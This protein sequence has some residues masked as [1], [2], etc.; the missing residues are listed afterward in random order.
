MRWPTPIEYQDALSDPAACLIAPD[1]QRS[2]ILEQTPYGSPLPV[3]GQFAHVYRL[4]Q[5]DGRSYAL[6]LFLREASDR[7][8]R[9][10]AI[11]AYIQSLPPQP[12]FVRFAYSPNGIRIGEQN[13]P[14]V[15][16]DWAEGEPLHVYIERHLNDPQRMKRLATD[17]IALIESLETLRIA[18]GD[19]QQDNLLVDAE[20]GA[21]HLIDYDGMFV[22]ALA[23][24]PS[25]E[26]GHP[27]YQHPQRDRS[28]FGPALDRFSALV[29]LVTLQTLCVAP[30]LWYRFHNGDN[31]LFRHE[32]FI[33][34]KE[35]NTF[36]TVRA[37]LRRSPSAS[38]SLG[39]LEAACDALPLEAPRL[40]LAL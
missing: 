40:E 13:F 16:M 27:A 25:A 1:L 4:R 7:A 26:L 19:L 37:A 23:G 36:R 5:I 29:I 31:L 30:D 18:H 3:A 9:Y 35:S 21:L 33:A 39:L 14:V 24:R 28:H 12:L 38:R 20:T 8:A 6:R 22:P 2:Q 11:Q 17:W 32:D 34:P 15:V 10:A